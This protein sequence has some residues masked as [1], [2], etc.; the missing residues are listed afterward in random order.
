[1]LI[2]DHEAN[3]LP[4]LQRVLRKVYLSIEGEPS[5]LATEALLSA[6]ALLLNDR[7]KATGATPEI[8]EQY[9]AEAAGLLMR[10]RRL[11]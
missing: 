7:A 11:T 5:K 1:M 3:A 2:V 9:V 4:E 8:V 6:Q 10:A